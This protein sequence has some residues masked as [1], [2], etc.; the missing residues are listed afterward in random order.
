MAAAR[1]ETKDVWQD[2][3]I[4]LPAA[5]AQS[6]LPRPDSWGQRRRRQSCVWPERE[7]G[8]MAAAPGFGVSLRPLVWPISIMRLLL[9]TTILA[10]AMSGQQALPTAKG[11]PTFTEDIASL[12]FKSCTKCHRPGEAGPFPLQSYRDVRKRGRNLLSVMED[13]IMPPWHPVPGFGEFRNDLRLA[14]SDIAMFRKW[15]EAGMPEGPAE[16]LPELPKYPEGWQLGQPDLVLKTSGA[17]PVPAGGRDIYRNFSLQLDLPEDKWLTALAV[18][19]GDREV[20]HHV[21]LFLDPSKS[22]RQKEGSDGKPGYRGRGTFRSEMVGGWAVGGQPEHL[23]LGLAIKIPKGSDLTLQSHLHPVGRKTEEQTTIGLYFAKQP[24]KS[25]VVSV[26]LPPFFGFMAGLDI[27][28]GKADF[29]LKDEF[30]L[31]CDVAAVTVGGHAHLLCRSLKM[32]AVLP[33]GKKVPLLHIADWDFDWQNRYT[34][35]HPVPLPKGAVIYSELHY[36][37]SEGNLDNPNSPPKRVRWGRET[38]DE[39]GSVTLLVTPTDQSDLGVLKRS[40]RGHQ[41]SAATTRMRNQLTN[42]FADF[43]TDGDEHLSESEVP[44][45]LRRFFERLDTD[46][47]GKLSLEEAKGLAKLFGRRR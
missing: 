26:Q 24:P 1:S 40:I 12:I 47:D 27:P 42:S 6:L 25:A 19:A 28:A 46:D 20:L 18:R 13:R 39:M 43:D 45:R 36:D 11:V 30:E 15:V 41:R 10:A 22:G 23:P 17:Y 14:D 8:L 33:D 34:F 35:A 31:P 37:N 32:H 3:Q 21:L 44:R 16:R 38:T 2:D 29:S 4:D 5:S 9:A 7:A